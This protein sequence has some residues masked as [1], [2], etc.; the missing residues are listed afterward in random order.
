MPAAASPRDSSPSRSSSLSHSQLLLAD[1]WRLLFSLHLTHIALSLLCAVLVL[2][3]WRRNTGLRRW[4]VH[5]GPSE[6]HME[7]RK[8]QSPFLIITFGTWKISSLKC[9]KTDFKS[10]SL[11]Q[12]VNLAAAFYEKGVGVFNIFWLSLCCKK[13]EKNTSFIFSFVACKRGSQRQFSMTWSHYNLGR[14]VHSR[15]KAEKQSEASARPSRV[16]W[17]LETLTTLRELRDN[18]NDIKITMFLHFFIYPLQAISNISARAIKY[19]Q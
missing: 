3:R 4:E 15:L 12:Y 11:K 6:K 1:S 9:H 16:D 10:L 14:G 17:L 5:S 7:K 8:A 18:K 2:E 13:K 19:Q